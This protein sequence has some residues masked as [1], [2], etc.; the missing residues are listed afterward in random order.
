MRDTRLIQALA[1]LDDANKMIGD[2]LD[3][4]PRDP[5]DVVALVSAQK[6]LSAAIRTIRAASW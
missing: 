6:F 2:I 3:E 1:E 4:S 5:Q